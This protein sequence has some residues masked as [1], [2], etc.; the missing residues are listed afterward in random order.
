MAVISIVTSENVGGWEWRLDPAD[1]E[2]LFRN[3]RG[4]LGVTKLW[5]GIDIGDM[6]PR[7]IDDYVDS[8]YWG[9]GDGAD[10]PVAGPNEAWGEPA[11]VHGLV[12]HE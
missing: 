12:H 4:Q 9:D 10:E 11:R 1:A 2:H 7:D 5:H 8:V 6:A 3:M